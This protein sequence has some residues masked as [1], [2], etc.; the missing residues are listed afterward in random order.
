[1]SHIICVGTWVI[2]TSNFASCNVCSE[3][4]SPNLL[5]LRIPKILASK[6]RRKTCYTY[7]NMACLMGTWV[8]LRVYGS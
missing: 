7:D 4:V 3:K 6:L 5:K 2:C 8:I 1:M